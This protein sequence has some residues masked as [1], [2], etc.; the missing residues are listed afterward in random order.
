MLSALQYSGYDVKHV[1][2]EG[3]H[4]GKH[5]AAIMPDALKWIW[6]DYPAPVKLQQG[7]QRRTDLLIDG[8][9]WQLVSSGHRFTEG[10]AVGADGSLYFTDIPANRIHR[11]SQ[12]GDV[13][14]FAED[15]AGTNG[16]ISG[17]DGHL[18]GCRTK[19][20]QIVRY[21]LADRKM[22]VVVEGIRANDLIILPDGSGYCTEL[23][24]GEVW[25]FRGD[26]SKRKVAEGLKRPNGLMTSPDQTLLTVSATDDRFCHSYQ[27]QPDG[28]LSFG[29]PYGW[30]HVTDTLMSGSD[31]MTVDSE[32]RMYVTTALGLQV[33]D[34]LGRVHFI[35]RKPQAM[36]LSNATF[37]GS[38][39]D[40][41]YV[42]CGDSVYRRRIRAKG[43]YPWESPVKPPKPGL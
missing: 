41:L 19:D 28:S 16:L 2:G 43:V 40:V 36:W 7:K 13:T 21:S 8:E 31:G 22:D 42:T 35:F 34:Q 32:G 10:P 25:H 24:A 39:R 12:D 17:P 26:G 30:L 14:V 37:G 23:N 9:D 18:Y 33:M 11:V 20:A 29:Q 4:N 5:G 3:G 38:E 6:R 27:I 15:T 1:W